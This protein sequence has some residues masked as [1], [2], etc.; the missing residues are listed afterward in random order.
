MD[1]NVL[2]ILCFPRTAIYLPRLLINFYTYGNNIAFKHLTGFCST[3]Y[4]AVIIVLIKEIE[5]KTREHR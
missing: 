3:T 4:L 2:M 1:I 5:L